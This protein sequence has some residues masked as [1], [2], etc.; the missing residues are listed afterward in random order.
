[1]SGQVRDAEWIEITLAE[2]AG[3]VHRRLE[4]SA[5]LA[6]VG[7]RTRGSVLA[8]RLAVQLEQLG[9]TV[10]TGDIDTTLYR[11][12]IAGAGGRK[13]IRASD[14]PFDVNGK[15]V[16]L[17]DDVLSTGRT[18]RAAMTELMDFGRPA[19]IRLLCLVDRG[20]RELP[21]QPDFIGAELAVPAEQKL[22]VRLREEDGRDGVDVE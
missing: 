5:D 11:D 2:L 13:A 18:V 16:L 21:I 6:I 20:G 1:M 22:R 3:E 10:E 7:V 4:P 19:C 14:L 17:V 8:G 15:T 9:R 12:D